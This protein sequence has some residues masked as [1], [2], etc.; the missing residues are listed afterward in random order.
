MCGYRVAVLTVL[1]RRR[2]EGSTAGGEGLALAKSR[3]H[4]AGVALLVE[5]IP[6]RLPHREPP[7]PG[8]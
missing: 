5:P 6:H 2:H 3:N 8:Q 1:V 7:V 4:A